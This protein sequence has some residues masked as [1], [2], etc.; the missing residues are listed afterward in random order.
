[1]VVTKNALYL[2]IATGMA[3]VSQIQL[4]SV[5]DT[6]MNQTWIPALLG[7]S[8]SWIWDVY[9]NNWYQVECCNG[10]EEIYG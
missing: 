1:M 4:G 3:L 9:I 2:P 7:F 6:S 5:E 10:L 8:L